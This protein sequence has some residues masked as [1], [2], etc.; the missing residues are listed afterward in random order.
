MSNTI[1]ARQ[2][3]CLWLVIFLTGC[4]VG[5]DYE[6]PEPELPDRWHID[7][8]YQNATGLV[9]GEARWVDVVHDKQLH[10]YVHEALI[11]NKSMLIA[12]ERIEEARATNRIRRAPLFPSLDLQLHS[13]RESDSE[14]TNTVADVED[15]FLLGPVVS[16]ELDL[17]GKNRRANRAAYADY[18]ATEYAAQATRLSLVADVSRAYFELQG[19]EARL[20]INHHTLS[21]REQSLTIAEKRFKGGLT[22]MLEVTQSQVA[23]ATTRSSLPKVEQRKL[24]LE[25]QLAVLLGGPPRHIVSHTVLENQYRPASVTV[26]LSS[27]LLQRRPDIM[28]A[29]QELIA[30]SESIG[31]ATAGLFPNFELT[32][33]FGYE[34][35]EFDDLLDSDGSTWIIE[36]DVLMP[37]FN[38][39]ARRAKVRVA[40]SQF[41][42]ARLNYELTVLEALREV[43]D[44]LNQF[45]KSG[46]TLDA[47]LYL[48]RAS[49]EYLRLATKR[50]RNGVL[51]YI[52]VLDAQRRLFDAQISVSTARQAQLF[53]LV[54]LYKA[55]GGGWEA[56][57]LRLAES[58]D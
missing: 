19:I 16:W 34:T 11:N 10:E 58:A 7:L 22:S 15:E 45:Y 55:L 9:L 54:D 27:Q 47:E 31:V 56:D 14:F 1:P 26:G 30:R 6:R 38:A 57:R 40:E 12:L 23:L 32:G 29:E 18:L 33:E 17:W 46:E 44:A 5:P 28:Q 36:L 20:A 50:Y 2:W 39:G 13:E 24:T 3:R 35:S 49:T 41:N 37:L 52:D 53:A 25:N 4:A 8:D 21:A 42:Q 43:S 51:P 48:E